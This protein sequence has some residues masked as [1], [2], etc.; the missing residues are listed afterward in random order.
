MAAINGSAH[1]IIIREDG[2][3]L[4]DRVHDDGLTKALRRT[5]YS[6]K[7]C[8]LRLQLMCIS[9]SARVFAYRLYLRRTLFAAISR[10]K[11]IR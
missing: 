2:G 6:C 5:D 11:D 1:Q 8:I 3:D 10:N 9:C 4:I 7:V